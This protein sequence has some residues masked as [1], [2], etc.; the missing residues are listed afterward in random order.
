MC[1]NLYIHIINDD[2]SL[3]KTVSYYLICN[4]FKASKNIQSKEKLSIKRGKRT[5][6]SN[7][8]EN[9]ISI[10]TIRIQKLLDQEMQLNSIKIEHEKKMSA[11]KEQHLIIIQ[12]HE[13]RA[14]IAAAETAELQLEM[15]R[16]EKMS[17]S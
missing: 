10:K 13:L 6:S 1:L 17:H 2:N 4:I 11:L 14:A 5:I 15:K 3:Y 9:E 16:N 12:K 7:D 8:D